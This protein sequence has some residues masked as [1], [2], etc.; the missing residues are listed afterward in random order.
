MES[1]RARIMRTMPKSK[2]RSK[3]V[4]C[5]RENWYDA[6]GIHLAVRI[7]PRTNCRCGLPIQKARV[8]LITLQESQGGGL[9]KS[10][11]VSPS[12]DRLGCRRIFLVFWIRLWDHYRSG[13]E[14]AKQYHASQQHNKIEKLDKRKWRCRG[15]WNPAAKMSAISIQFIWLWLSVVVK[16]Q[17]ISC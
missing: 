7:H 6:V 16:G 4:A 8:T 15:A 5:K 10:I 17:K 2:K 14:K 1:T 9:S 3:L 12:G 13:L 11:I